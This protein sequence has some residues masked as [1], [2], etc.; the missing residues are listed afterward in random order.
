MFITFSRF[1]GQLAKLPQFL[2][3]AFDLL[4]N[5]HLKLLP[6]A[7]PQEKPQIIEHAVVIGPLPKQLPNQLHFP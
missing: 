2:T 1:I 6:S 3:I 5:N 7:A 4:Y